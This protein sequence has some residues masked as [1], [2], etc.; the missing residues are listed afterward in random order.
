MRDNWTVYRDKW[1]A[2]VAAATI[3]R[4]PNL[5]QVPT[6]GYGS[7]ETSDKET[8]VMS[9][10]VAF[11]RPIGAPLLAILAGLLA[12]KPIVAMMN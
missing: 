11:T 4:N 3:V 12:Y 9:Y 7:A 10:V 6:R 8:L 5:L 2:E 1:G